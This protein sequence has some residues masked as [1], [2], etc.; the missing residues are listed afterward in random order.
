MNNLLKVQ[1]WLKNN[2][3]DVNKNILTCF[4]RDFSMRYNKIFYIIFFIYIFTW[5]MKAIM[6]D[7]I[8]SLP[9]YRIITKSLK[10]KQIQF[11]CSMH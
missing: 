2:N 1:Q 8:G 7:D 4:F 5:N 10:I 11:K 3:I 6:T 9:Y